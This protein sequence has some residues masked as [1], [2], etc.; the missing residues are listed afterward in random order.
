M[1][2]VKS[3]FRFHGGVHPEYHKDLA[4]D[5]AIE[6]IPIPA[7]LVISMSQHLGAP[8]KCLVKAGDKVVKGQL[9]GEKG[10]EA[11]RAA[12][13]ELE[14]VRVCLPTLCHSPIV[15][16]QS[17]R[18]FVHVQ[19]VEA[20]DSVKSHVPLRFWALRSCCRRQV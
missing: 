15:R 3:S 2:I 11:R 4:R 18:A 16:E 8:A 14:L 5:K 9:I 19:Y 12:R 13:E 7:T 10:L 17:G 20:R 1:K 6:A